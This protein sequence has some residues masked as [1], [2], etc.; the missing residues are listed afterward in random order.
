MAVDIKNLIAAVNPSLYCNSEVKSEVKDLV[1]DSGFLKAAEKAKL[2]DPSYMDFINI[3]YNNAMS[4]KG[5]KAPLEQHTLIYDSFGEGLEAIY[6][7]LID[8]AG[9]MYKKV[10]KVIDNFVSSPGSSHFSEM[11][12]RLTKMQ[13]EGMKMLGAA[14]QVLK[15][16]LNIIFDLKE[17]KMRL[18]IYEKLKAESKEE[19][20]SAMLSLK[21]I[22]LDTVD[23]K[24]GNSSIKAL[25]LSQQGGFVTLIDAF[26]A[27]ENE[28]LEYKGQKIDLNDRVLRLLQQRIGEFLIWIKESERELKKRYEVE[29][30]YLKSQVN[31]VKLYARWAK[32]YLKATK[33]LEQ[34]ASSTAAL[35]TLFI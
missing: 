16:I 1:K 34:R 5:L 21:Q 31:T 3:G 10:D 35:V 23:F 25:A 27:V 30:K 17:F 28:K 18:A 6:F 15:S 32:P 29:R 33:D 19:G 13:E 20:E 4:K 2:I 7:W 11:G 9:N 14:N 26:M 22:W 8:F 24:K 12:M